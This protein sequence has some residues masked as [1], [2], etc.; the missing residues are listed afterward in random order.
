MRRLLLAMGVL[1]TLSPSV[2]AEN[3]V[4][5]RDGKLRSPAILEL[6][7]P[8]TFDMYGV[9][10][11]DWPALAPRDSKYVRGVLQPLAQIGRAHV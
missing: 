6:K 4:F 9:E 8:G 7:N 3:L 2:L 11:A 1:A 5:V 10:V